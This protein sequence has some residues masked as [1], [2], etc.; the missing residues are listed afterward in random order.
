M[1]ANPP[2]QHRAGLNY[3]PLLGTFAGIRGSG[4]KLTSST[5]VILE[6]S[7]KEVRSPGGFV[8]S[9]AFVDIYNDSGASVTAQLWLV[10]ADGS[11]TQ[12]AA[13][14]VIADATHDAFSPAS[15][16]PGEGERIEVRFSAGNVL[17]QDGVRVMWSWIVSVKSYLSVEYKKL[18]SPVLDV[19][20]VPGV[21][22]TAGAVLVNFSA[23]AVDFVTKRVW[24]DGFEEQVGT[25][26]L[27][28]S[29]SP[30]S[31]SL[32]STSA[33]LDDDW[34]LRVEFVTLP[35]NGFVWAMPILASK[36]NMPAQDW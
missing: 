3:P 23:Q 22:C 30:G 27:A 5:L 20:S 21:S 8:G 25:A 29:G 18:T 16:V 26:T 19:E 6:G 17:A 35:A 34:K 36:S 2:L 9:S 13:D 11:E 32:E 15:Y 1:P 7:D 28:A 4:V 24:P 10:L 33:I 14:L 12:I 31:V